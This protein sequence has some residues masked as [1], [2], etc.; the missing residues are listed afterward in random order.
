MVPRLGDSGHHKTM[1]SL[2][3]LIQGISHTRIKDYYRERDCPFASVCFSSVGL[4]YMS[5]N[6]QTGPATVYPN[7]WAIPQQDRRAGALQ[8]P[9]GV[10]AHSAG[11]VSCQLWVVTTY[12]SRLLPRQRAVLIIQV[13][14]WHYIRN[15]ITIKLENL[16]PYS[17]GISI[18]CGPMICNNCG[19]CLWS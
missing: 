5:T 18:T 2:F 11:S 15:W 3:V 13:G 10:P 14:S 1:W 19:G 12:V 9:R 8:E 7:A 17:H 6:I 16:K 4:C